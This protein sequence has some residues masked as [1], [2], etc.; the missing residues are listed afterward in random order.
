[1]SRRVLVTGAGG[2]IGTILREDFADRYDFTLVDSEVPA[3]PGWCRLDVANEYDRLKDL[4]AGH[5]AVVHL[6]YVA[7]DET[8]CTNE[9]M[10]KNVYRA[11]L[12]TE[13]HPRVVV[14]S[15]VHV[16]G[17]H[18][19]WQDE[20]YSRIARLPRRAPDV[21]PDPLTAAHRL[22]PDSPYGAIKA[23]AE[24]LGG[25]YAA[26]GLQVVVLRFGGVR[27]DDHMLDE[28]GYHT[29]WLSRR[30]CAAAVSRAIEADVAEHFTVVFAVSNNTYRIHDLSRARRILGF[31]PQDDS[32]RVLTGR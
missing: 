8:G 30:D 11:A 21:T 31:E 4:A 25:V 22:L 12:E 27:R 14:A 32:A 10:A 26:R 15:S 19:N 9:L 18:V 17:G 20:P 28:V 3:L 6:G 2:T 5:D 7:D 24:L 16:V 1:M 23:Y 13:P 29:F